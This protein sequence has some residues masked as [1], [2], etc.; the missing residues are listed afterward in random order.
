MLQIPDNITCD[1]QQSP[2]PYCRPLNLLNGAVGNSI[3]T[4]VSM[5]TA[6]A[7]MGGSSIVFALSKT[8]IFFDLLEACF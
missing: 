6:Y 8:H 5:I 4:I 7:L 1:V 3:R 2:Q